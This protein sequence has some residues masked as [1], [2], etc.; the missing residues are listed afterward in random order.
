MKKTIIT[1]AIILAVAAASAAAIPFTKSLK[2]SGI[3]ETATRSVPAYSSIAAMRGVDVVIDPAAEKLTVRADDNV[4][5]YVITEVEDSTLTV[6]ISN[7][8]GSMSNCKIKVTVPGNGNISKISA[9][10][11]ADIENVGTLRAQNMEISAASGSDIDLAVECARCTVSAT[12]GADIDLKASVTEV[13]IKVT[14]GADINIEGKADTCTISATSG[15]DCDAEKMTT[16]NCT[17]SAT[18]GAS[19]EVNCSGTLNANATS[20]ASVKYR[21]SCTVVSKYGSGG[22]VKQ[23]E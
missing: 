16:R 20:G 19:V 5:G 17:V 3:M 18:S 21:G 6:T 2:G 13:N 9:S 1:L 10:R 15:A 11:A 22:R 8:V 14:S 23:D 4:I 7:E 12:G